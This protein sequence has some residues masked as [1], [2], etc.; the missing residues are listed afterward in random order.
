VPLITRWEAGLLTLNFVNISS[1]EWIGAEIQ[2]QA[3][4]VWRLH[5]FD[6]GQTQKKSSTRRTSSFEARY[7]SK[8]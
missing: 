7:E 6:P 2:N 5:Y 3:N 4:Q 8:T 1:T